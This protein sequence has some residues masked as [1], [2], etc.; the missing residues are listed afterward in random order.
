MEN[1]I[2]PFSIFNFPLS[3]LRLARF[4]HVPLRLASVLANLATILT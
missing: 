1:G 2:G 3:P 4:P